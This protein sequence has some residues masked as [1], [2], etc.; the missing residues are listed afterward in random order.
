MKSWSLFVTC[1][2]CF[3]GNID[4]IQSYSH[5]YHLPGGNKRTWFVVAANLSTSHI[6]TWRFSRGINS[7]H[8]ELASIGRIPKGFQSRLRHLTRLVVAIPLGFGERLHLPHPWGPWTL[9]FCN[10]KSLKSL[11]FGFHP[12]HFWSANLWVF[13]CFCLFF[14]RCDFNLALYT[15]STAKRRGHS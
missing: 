10:L 9:D 3:E 4:L 15:P 7:L 2:F 14:S 1:F 8:R 6:T 12:F 5:W 11:K 13:V